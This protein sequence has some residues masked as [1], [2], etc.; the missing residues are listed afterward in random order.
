M[1]DI[2]KICQEVQ[3]RGMSTM[4]I[5][6]PESMKRFVEQQVRDGDY[7]GASDYVRALI[8]RDRDLAEL[9]SLLDKGAASAVEGGFD[10]E[11]FDGLRQDLRARAKARKRA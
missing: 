11:Y 6:L 7:A 3:D 9:R 8:R 5:S 10:S 4:N 2:D 1:T